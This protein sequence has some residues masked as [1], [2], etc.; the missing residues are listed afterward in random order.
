M[1]NIY[2]LTK[3]ITVVIPAFILASLIICKS[4]FSI[5][6]VFFPQ[7]F[8]FEYFI[9]SIYFQKITMCI[10]VIL[11]KILDIIFVSDTQ[12]T[13]LILRIL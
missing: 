2:H 8:I 5:F 7:I 13:D 6:V 12:L 1:R 3:I 4:L 9:C 10:W 11:L